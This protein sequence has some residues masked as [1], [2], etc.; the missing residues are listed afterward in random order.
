MK[1]GKI[2]NRKFGGHLVFQIVAICALLISIA[3]FF[4]GNWFESENNS[5]LSTGVTSNSEDCIRPTYVDREN[6]LVRDMDADLMDDGWE[7]FYRFDSS[8]PNDA[9]LD[10][11]SDG[12]TNLEEFQTETSP[13]S[14]RSFPGVTTVSDWSFSCVY[15]AEIGI[16]SDDDLIDILIRDPDE[17]YFPYIPDFVMVQQPNQDFV[18]EH[19]SNFEIPE[20][21]A[22]SDTLIITDLNA[23]FLNDLALV[24]LSDH[25][26]GVDDQFVFSMPYAFSLGRYID[27][28]DTFPLNHVALGEKETSFFSE[29]EGWM[30]TYYLEE[31]Y[32]ESNAQ[33]VAAV[34]E[35]L[36]LRWTSDS[37]GSA[38]RS[39]E[40]IGAELI[41][42][43]CDNL[44][45]NCF[46]VIADGNDSER[47]SAIDNFVFEYLP[48][49]FDLIISDAEDNANQENFYFLVQAIFSRDSNIVL[50][51]YS[52]F[53][54]DALRLARNELQ[55]VVEAGVM[56][57]PSPEA[58]TIIDYLNENL[59]GTEVFANRFEDP[60][61]STYGMN[62]EHL[63]SRNIAGQVQ[64]VLSFVGN[65]YIRR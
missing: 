56:F 8:N 49:E 15:V 34:P 11:D 20:L 3:C 61:G 33:V 41:P 45:T 24:N 26:P 42:A 62:F 1:S 21:T 18:L 44:F 52:S 7:T 43:D 50:K 17:N 64:R 53:N 48:S 27:Q 63:R 13:R 10:S 55:S 40:P 36:E 12:Y 51:D 30:R 37:T 9:N 46:S 54:Q 32:F 6:I 14:S 60:K 23:D 38:V 16:I 39:V 59:G 35:L 31:D 4:Q 57:F 28:S 47:S 65:R 19:A 5:G 25:I 22:I 58:T 2:Q 29:L